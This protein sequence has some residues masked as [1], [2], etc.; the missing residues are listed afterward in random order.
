MWCPA[1]AGPSFDD[2]YRCVTMMSSPAS[3]IAG[4]EAIDNQITQRN[5]RDTQQGLSFRGSG[6]SENNRR[7]NRE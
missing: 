5:W 1:L 2:C 6:P 7:K 3:V 4:R